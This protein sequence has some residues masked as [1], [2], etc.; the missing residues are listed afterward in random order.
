MTVPAATAAIMESAPAGGSGMASAVFNVARQVGNALGV[1]LFGTLA[2]T[3]GSLVAGVHLSAVIASGAFALG[4]L[5]AWRTGRRAAPSPVA[6]LD[7]A[8]P[9]YAAASARSPEGSA[10]GV[11]SG[12]VS[13]GEAD[14]SAWR[15]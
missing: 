4:A 1:A 14:A 3:G 6:H 9:N 15:A 13:D 11:A 12:S 8:P 5:L 10:A 7:T 2:A